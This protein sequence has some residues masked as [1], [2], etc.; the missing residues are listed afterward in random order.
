MAEPIELDGG[1][2]VAGIV[3]LIILIVLFVALMVVFYRKSV[4]TLIKQTNAKRL[5]QSNG[6][7]PLG[8]GADG[9]AT[10]VIIRSS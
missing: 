2:Y 7:S 10:S 4:E 5:I 9:G 6:G 3:A 1:T 8:L